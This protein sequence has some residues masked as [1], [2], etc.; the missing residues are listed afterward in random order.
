LS[1]NSRVTVAAKNTQPM[2]FAALHLAG[3]ER[4][5]VSINLNVLLE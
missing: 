5:T 2:F 1:G 4:L 3:I